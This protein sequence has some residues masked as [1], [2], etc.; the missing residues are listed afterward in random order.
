[1]RGGVSARFLRG[2]QRR[3]SSP[4]C[5]WL[6][7]SVVRPPGADWA[8]STVSVVLPHGKEVEAP[9]AGRGGDEP[10][11]LLLQ[12]GHVEEADTAGEREGEQGGWIGGAGLGIQAT[13]VAPPPPRVRAE[14]EPLR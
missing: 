2:C 8:P 11:A 12:V 3:R 13:G 4:L 1:M 14:E 6:S 10:P 5:R 7:S 9:G